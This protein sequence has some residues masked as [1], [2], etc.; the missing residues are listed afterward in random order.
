MHHILGC[1]RSD[2]RHSFCY[3]QPASTQSEAYDLGKFNFFVIT[4][5]YV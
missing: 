5:L 4:V 2:D 3:E 1:L